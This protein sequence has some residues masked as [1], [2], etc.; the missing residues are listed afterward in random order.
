MTK[1]IDS[2]MDSVYK[3]GNTPIT[4]EKVNI[5]RIFLQRAFP[6]VSNQ[7]VSDA[8]SLLAVYCCLVSEG[9]RISVNGQE[10][11]ANGLSKFFD[12]YAK[13]AENEFSDLKSLYDFY[14]SALVVS[15]FVYK[16][17]YGLTNKEMMFHKT[18]GGDKSDRIAAAINED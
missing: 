5:L 4:K 16:Y 3:E 12:D 15:M 11:D 17:T 7:A 18:K 1:N 14:G 13:K 2:L 6:D 8:A 9:K 10:L